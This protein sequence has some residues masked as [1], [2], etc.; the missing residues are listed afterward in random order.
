M[1]VESQVI[2]S[3]TIETILKIQA[4]NYKILKKINKFHT[5]FMEKI[6]KDKLKKK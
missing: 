2:W 6:L 4:G 1:N 3:A 5:G